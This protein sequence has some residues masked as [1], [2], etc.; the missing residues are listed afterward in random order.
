MNATTDLDCLS[1][2]EMQAYGARCL[3]LFCANYGIIHTS[4]DKLIFHLAS[5]LSATNLSEWDRHGASLDL[6]GRGDAIPNDLSM[7]LP[8]CLKEDFHHLVDSVVEIGISDL[9]G[10][11]TELPFMFTKMAVD[12]LT[13]HNIRAPS[14]CDIFDCSMKKNQNNKWGR[15]ISI[16]EKDRIY[17]KIIS[18][19]LS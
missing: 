14:L 8:Q 1:I 13:K 17:N 10:T 2:R 19:K 12:I 7:I 5:M 15:A 9:Y 11:N 4:I 3:F 18:Q 6:T 16:L